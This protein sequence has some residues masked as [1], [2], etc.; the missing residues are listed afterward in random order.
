[1]G[2][3]FQAT[4]NDHIQ[5]DAYPLPTVEEVFARISDAQ[6]FAKIDLKSAYS[7]IALD[8]ESKSLSVIN[9]TK[10]LFV[11]N[12][13]Q[14]GMKNVSAIF[15]IC[16]DD[17][18]KGI[19]GVMVYQHDVKI[20]AANESQLHNRLAQVRNRLK[21]RNVTINEEKSKGSTD[22]I[23]FLGF[24]FYNEGIVPYT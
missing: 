14:M 9:T 7:Q 13:L 16:M 12:R 18:M 23:T 6:R 5:S 3:D 2:V 1:M 4:L 8:D 22:S 24:T 15:Q 11:L 19:S 10:G 20:C 21:E 17:I